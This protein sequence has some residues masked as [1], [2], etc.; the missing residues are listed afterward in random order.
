MKNHIQRFK[1]IKLKNFQNIIDLYIS[2]YS[3]TKIA[4]QFSISV[5]SLTKILKENHIKIRN[6]SDNRKLIYTINENYFSTIDSEEKSYFLGLMYSDGCNYHKKNTIQICLQEEDKYILEKFNKALSSNRQL[7]YYNKTSP[8]HQNKYMLR[9]SNKKLS[10]DLYRLGCI[11]KKSLIL[12][13]PD[14]NIV[15]ENLLNHFIRGYFDGDGTIYINK[16]SCTYRA[17]I[18]VSDIF[19]IEY[20]DLIKKIL[21]IHVSITIKKNNKIREATISGGIQTIKFLDWIYNNATIYLHRKHDKYKDLKPYLESRRKPKSS[22]Y[23]GV[24]LNQNNKYHCY[25]CI[26]RKSNYIGQFLNEKDAAIAYDKKIIE[27][28]LQ[29]KLNF[30]INNYH[31]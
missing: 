13:F 17:S 31:L 11:P 9:I 30:P 2:G 22:K 25:Y 24:S 19:G 6:A 3:L 26:G 8:N 29:K 10:N 7:K 28:K 15:P 5:P 16:K 23:Y 4:K 20:K 27:L 1:E 12:A 14:Y 21:N 18:C